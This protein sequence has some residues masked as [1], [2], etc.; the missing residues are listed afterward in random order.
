[1]F[2]F[3][4]ML[5]AKAVPARRDGSRLIV[6]NKSSIHW[7]TP[8]LV[9]PPKTEPAGARRVAGGGRPKGLLLRC[10]KHPSRRRGATRFRRGTKLLL[11]TSL[12]G[13]DDTR[14][15]LR[16]I[17]MPSGIVKAANRPEAKN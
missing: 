7:A 15:P 16:L 8:V 3:V 1:V 11:V 5:P 17:W 9:R 4:A 6:I 14:S 2:R 13:T 12:T 10:R